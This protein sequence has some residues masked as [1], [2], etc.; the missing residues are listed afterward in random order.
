MDPQT[1]EEFEKF[2][3]DMQSGNGGDQMQMLNQMMGQM[4]AGMGATPGDGSSA[5]GTQGKMPAGF[6]NNLGDM[7]KNFEDNPEYDQLAN[8]LLSE[9]MDKDILEEPLVDSQKKYVEYLAENK[10]KLSPSDKD[11]FTQQLRCVEEILV[12]V[13][14]DSENKDKMIAKFEEMQE[15]GQPPE[16]L[17]NAFGG[18]SP[19]AAFTNPAGNN[20]ESS[21]NSAGEL[22]QMPNPNDCSIF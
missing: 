7:F 9:F 12:I 5:D 2:M 21:A 22:P 19:F 20:S 3:K 8:N 16:P 4:F 11:R 18:D 10:D 14:T 1:K 6:Q 17:L 15:Y 13:R